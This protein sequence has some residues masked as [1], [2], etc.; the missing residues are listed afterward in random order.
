MKKSY[1]NL[2]FLLPGLITVMS[3]GS[4]GGKEEFASSSYQVAAVHYLPDWQMADQRRINDKENISSPQV[5]CE[6]YGFVSSCENPKISSGL[7]KPR[8]DL[9]C[10]IS[11]VC[12]DRYI[13]T[14]LNCGSEA[15]WQLGSRLCEGKADACIAVACPEGYRAGLT[16]CDSKQHPEGWNY[17]YNGYSGGEVCGRC[18]AKTCRDDS[19]RAGQNNCSAKDQPKGWNYLSEGFAGDDI[20]GKCVEK[21]CNSGFSAGVENCE[22]GWS[23]SQDKSTPYAGNQVCGQ[24]AIALCAEDYTAGLNDC[25]GFKN[26]V[27]MKYDHKGK[28]GTQVC[29]RCTE[30]TCTEKNALCQNSSRNLDFYYKNS[31]L[32]CLMK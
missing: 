1:Y 7:V 24:C 3:P 18:T 17:D 6:T 2:A 30:M 23:Y 32:R 9:V 26:A 11:C 13:Y 27:Y 14:D 21:S 5:N 19:Y 28:S 25:Q 15:G 4:A 12:P 20:C 31:A 10:Q 8:P 16:N 29:G 22:E